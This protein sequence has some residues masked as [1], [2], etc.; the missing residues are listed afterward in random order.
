MSH[1]QV[2]CSHFFG[3]FATEDAAESYAMSGDESLWALVVFNSDPT[4]H[5][6]GGL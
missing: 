5:S 4:L 1:Q 2:V 6:A 3:V